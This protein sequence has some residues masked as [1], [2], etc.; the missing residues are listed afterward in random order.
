MNEL[1]CAVL[2]VFAADVGVAPPSGVHREAIFT[3]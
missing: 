3:F 1:E 2:R